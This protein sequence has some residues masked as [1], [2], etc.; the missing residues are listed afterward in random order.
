MICPNC[1]T[2]AFDGLICH[3][4]GYRPLSKKEEA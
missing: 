3:M 4:C 1:K 2:D